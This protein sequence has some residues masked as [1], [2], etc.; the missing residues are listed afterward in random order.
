[1]AKANQS[2]EQQ[3]P[4]VQLRDSWTH[5]RRKSTE[6]DS[7]L[8]MLC[9]QSQPNRTLRQ[10]A[11]TSQLIS[12]TLNLRVVILFGEEAQVWVDGERKHSFSLFTPE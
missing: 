12:K 4:C 11:E 2:G 5:Y 8:I 6:K 1:M 9:P 10:K 7:E 3:Q